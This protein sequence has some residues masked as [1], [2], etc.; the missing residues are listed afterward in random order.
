[1]INNSLFDYITIRGSIIALRLIAPLS[2]VYLPCGFLN[3][4]GL[5]WIYNAPLTLYTSAEAVFYLLVYLPRRRK[6]Q[7]PPIHRPPYLTQ[8]QRQRIFEK[9]LEADQVHRTL[10][11]T[12][13]R[14]Y[15]TG[16]FLPAESI[17]TR[18]DAIDW[19]LWALFSTSRGTGTVDLEEE[20]VKQELN[21]YIERIEQAMGTRLDDDHFDENEGHEDRT[22]RVDEETGRSESE[23]SKDTVR[24]MRITLDPV[25]ML[26]RPLLWYFIVCL[27]DTYATIYLLFLGFKHYSPRTREHRLCFPPRPI[28]YFVSRSK[29]PVIFFHGIGIGLYPYIP[30]IKK[31]FPGDNLM[32]GDVGVLLPEL[33]P[34][35]MHMTPLS[36][37]PRSEMLQSLDLILDHLKASDIGSPHDVQHAH[38]TDETTGESIEPISFLRSS[39]PTTSFV[40]TSSTG[41]SLP[42]YATITPSQSQQSLSIDTAL[43][44]NNHRAPISDT[45][46]SRVVLVAHSYGTFVAGWMMRMCVDAD[47]FDRDDVIAPSLSPALEVEQSPLRLAH[48]IAHVVLV[49]PIPILLSDPTVAH[50]FLYRHPGTVCPI[51]LGCANENI[52]VENIGVTGINEGEFLVQNSV[53][54]IPPPNVS[55]MMMPAVN[56]AR[57]V[58][59]RLKHTFFSRYYSSAAA[60]QLWY[61]ASRDADVARTLC[62]TFFWAEGGM[63][64]EEVGKFVC[65]SG[66]IKYT[67]SDT[68]YAHAGIDTHR[69][70]PTLSVPN[71]SDLEVGRGKETFRGRNVAVFLGGMDQIVPAEAIRIHLTRER[72][73]TRWWSAKGS[74]LDSNGYINTAPRTPAGIDSDLGV[75]QQEVEEEQAFHALN[76]SS[77]AVETLSSSALPAGKP[78]VVPSV[79]CSACQGDHSGMLEVL[80]NPDLDHAVIFDHKEYTEPL[81]EVVRRYTGDR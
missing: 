35:S 8:A 51:M 42:S 27:V 31:V 70:T 39:S 10:G 59:K 79:P 48:K 5:S 29:M 64:R 63:W 32:E 19:L 69:R 54:A 14:P 72:R 67:C 25:Q 44:T 80:F 49:D 38:Y 21:G 33:L 62:R 55:N 58:S 37:P 47:L 61:F 28:L 60:W 73:C 66:N 26:H 3:T 57:N 23:R 18:K 52:E 45:D 9:C 81:V 41:A 46:W 76:T 34:I 53:Q 77:S 20:G 7:E 17:P 78:C 56:S 43:D 68:S 11:Y 6:L 75:D 12:H 13:G 24:S 4:F 15:P 16:W 71:H 50:N 74:D 22:P 30:F 40:S 2:I 36:V 1:M 65:G